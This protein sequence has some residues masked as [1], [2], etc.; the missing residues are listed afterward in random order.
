MVTSLR[1]RDKEQKDMKDQIEM[2]I[3][4]LP[5]K[6]EIFSFADQTLIKKFEEQTVEH[7]NKISLSCSGRTVTY[8]KLNQLANHIA[9]NIQSIDQQCNLPVAILLET[10]IEFVAAMLAVLKCG[11]ICIAINPSAPQAHIAD[12]LADSKATVLVSNSNV[13]RDFKHSSLVAAVNLDTIESSSLCS[14]PDLLV[15]PT[16][17]G[18]IMYTS[19]STG[20]PKGVVHSHKNILHAV[21]NCTNGLGIE[22][23]DRIALL[24]SGGVVAAIR[25]IFS[26][27]LNG[28]SLH[29]FDVQKLGLADL[30]LWLI[31]ERISIYY[32]PCSIFRHFLSLE[33]DEGK[34]HCV[35]VVRLGGEPVRRTDVELFK[36]N[37]TEPALLINGLGCT[38]TLTYCWCFL[39]TTCDVPEGNLPVGWETIDYSVSIVDAQGKPVA[40]N[41]HGEMIVHSEYLAD[42]Y[43]QNSQLTEERFGR[44]DVDNRKYFR[45]GDLGVRRPDGCIE[46]Q[47]RIDDQVKI[48]GNRIELGE[49]EQALMKIPV[50]HQV[51]VIPTKDEENKRLITFFVPVESVAN[52]TE[53]LRQSLIEL[54]PL[55]MIPSQFVAVESIPLTVS[56]KVDRELLLSRLETTDLSTEITAPRNDVEKKLVEIWRKLLDLK[57]LGI[58][59][60]FF[61]VGG[62]SM[63]A[64]HVL[65]RMKNVDVAVSLREFN[66]YPTIAGLS[67]LTENRRIR[68]ENIDTRSQSVELLPSQIRFFER[69]SLDPHHWNISEL[70]ESTNPLDP[71]HLR[72]ATQK[73]LSIH[74]SLRIILKKGST[75]WRIQGLSDSCD[76]NFESIDVATHS[77]EEQHQI[78]ESILRAKAQS[79]NL[80]QGLLFK[81]VYFECGNNSH[82]LF[83]V[84]HH[85]A[86]DAISW[87]V[88]VGDFFRIYSK[89]VEGVSLV[90]LEK[91][92]LGAW[93]E[94]LR[95]LSDSKE[96]LD[97]AKALIELPWHKV[98][99]IPKDLVNQGNNSNESAREIII[100]INDVDSKAGKSLTALAME[101]KLLVVLTRALSRWQK[102]DTVLFDTLS[103]GR[104][105]GGDLID[106][107]ST[108]GFFAAYSPVF[109]SPVLHNDVELDKHFMSQFWRVPDGVFDVVRTL[110]TDSKVVAELDRLPKAEILFN[111]SGK[112]VATDDLYNGVK[113]AE[114]FMLN[115]HSRQALRAYPIAIS[116]KT[117]GEVLK[118]RIVYS[119]NI[120]SESTIKILSGLLVSEFGA[121]T[122]DTIASI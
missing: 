95:K 51:A 65:S 10:G 109:I 35:R 33:N 8:S 116:A 29:I 87:R 85:L 113:S 88:L 50:V 108:T 70:F 3:R 110:G 120:H 27:L 63:I 80:E 25:D 17:P 4:P 97:Y 91:S 62:D 100:E 36:K 42:G 15:Q 58:H 54:L 117:S 77:R 49:V 89:L 9:L 60:N 61:S 6:K 94:H 81:V 75:K 96:Y 20:K 64:M 122:V 99:A 45:T 26:A 41:D 5:R 105:I 31:E 84:A 90:G 37:F 114:G 121:L 112:E 22:P 76:K 23:D 46:V 18:F 1:S 16:D 52:L 38:E 71:L 14:N 30:R 55:H 69:N 68:V 19:G 56:G 92:N 79:L 118:V 66:E 102:T 21:W 59:D 78:I 40:L 7:G 32:S 72:T 101:K 57:V 11:N 93:S 28:A 98:R 107:Y 86:S 106:V 2:D 111:Y 103:H 67:A 44:S 83:L 48:R 47:G 43:W 12:L 13:L 74:D 34:I 24:V 104:D 53:M 39:S 119:E 115:N 73:L 82:Y